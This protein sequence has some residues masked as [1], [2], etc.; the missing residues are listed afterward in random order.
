MSLIDSINEAD[1]LFQKVPVIDLKNIK[2]KDPEVRKAL[3]E[4]V[5]NACM[6][7]GFFYAA[8]EFFSLP[9]DTKM[10]ARRIWSRRS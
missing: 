1:T 8:R 6:V 3:V 5:R 2:T 7:V 10:K 4:E 9:V